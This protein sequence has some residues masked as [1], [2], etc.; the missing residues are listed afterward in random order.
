M[1]VIALLIGSLCVTSVAS[2]QELPRHSPTGQTYQK[3]FPEN[4]QN[5]LSSGELTPVKC[6]K[7]TTHNCFIWNT[8]NEYDVDSL[9]GG[10]VRMYSGGLER[11]REIKKSGSS[12]TILKYEFSWD[13]DRREFAFV[14]E[15]DFNRALQNPITP[16]MPV[17][18]V[19]EYSC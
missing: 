11:M 4:P 2:A 3:F 17:M 13:G 16:W 6:T 5:I 19:L 9:D 18:H 12:E 8:S 1:R 7:H 15:Q 10:C 14:Y